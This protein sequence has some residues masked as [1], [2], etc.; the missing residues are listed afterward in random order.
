MDK[1]LAVL[2]DGDNISATHAEHILAFA[3]GSGRPDV[4][5]VYGNNNGSAAWQDIPGFRFIHSGN[6]KNASDILLAMDAVEFALTGHCD[7]F[8]IVSSDRDFA[9][10]AHRLREKGQEVMGMGEAKSPPAFRSACTR[11][12]EITATATATSTTPGTGPSGPSD[13]DHKIRAMIAEHSK[14]GAGMRIKELGPK[15]RDQN[16]I[17]ISNYPERKWRPYLANRPK[18]YDLDPKGPDAKVRFK[19]DG[20]Q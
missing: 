19:P 18:L 15:M 17:Q 11:F 3:K 2:V 13:L 6:A 14:K 9:Q 8:L 1:K 5:R 20:F 4:V 10:L 16:G 12:V 7:L